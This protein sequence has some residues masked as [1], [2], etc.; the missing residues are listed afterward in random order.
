MGICVTC[1]EVRRNVVGTMREVLYDFFDQG[2]DG[3]FA[4]EIL[5][6]RESMKGT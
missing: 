6:R 1:S 5:N 2:L 3:F 4:S